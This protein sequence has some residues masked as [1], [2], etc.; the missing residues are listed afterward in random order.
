M[1][2]THSLAKAMV[3]K[4]AKL[5]A[6]AIGLAVMVGSAQASIVYSL[7]DPNTALALYPSPYA[8]V[9]VSRT[10][11]TTA[12]VA[13]QSLSTG[14]YQ[15]LF[16]DGS[17]GAVNVNAS[18]FTVSSIVGSLDAGLGTNFQSWS[19]VSTGPGNVSTFGN[20]NLTIN[21]FDGF[22]HAISD[23]AFTLTNTSGTWATDADVLALNGVGG[24]V[25]AAHIA[26][27]GVGA[28]DPGTA[29]LAT[30][31]VAGHDFTIP[32][33]VIPE[34]GSLALLGLGLAGLAVGR[35]SK[36]A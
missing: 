5:V 25:A 6:A 21:S 26:V 29:A 4:P 22:A 15:Y 34:P 24:E 36:V 35:R 23:L 18:T 31:F 30:G 27:C 16:I 28:C 20:F 7:V 1:K 13:F 14:G 3:T 9:T 32:P 17:S 19:L 10:S 12:N 33:V 11:A 8:T 2:V